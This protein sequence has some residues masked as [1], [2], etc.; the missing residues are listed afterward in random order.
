MALPKE[1]T[2]LFRSNVYPS[3][4]LSPSCLPALAILLQSY[5]EEKCRDDLQGYIW[6]R[7]AP[8]V[9]VDLTQEN[10]PRLTV[11]M[12]H[13]GSVE[14]EWLAVHL[15]LLATKETDFSGTELLKKLE[16]WSDGT[17]A[18]QHDGLIVDVSDE[19]GQFL[20][21]EGADHLPSWVQ[22]DNADGRLWLS[23]GQIHLITPDMHKGDILPRTDSV[24]AGDASAL[25]AQL[26]V[27]LVRL[28]SI[29]TAV[30]PS[31][32]NAII[33]QRMPSFPDLTWALYN[34]HS[35]LAYLPRKAAIALQL[36]PQLVANAAE[37]FEGREGPSDARRL[38]EMKVFGPQ[39]PTPIADAKKGEIDSNDTLLV[40]VRLPRRLY[41]TFLVPRY[42]PTKAFGEDWRQ[43]VSTYWEILEKS[44]RGDDTSDRVDERNHGRRRDLGCKIACG[45]ELAYGAAKER[46]KGK[47][48]DLFGNAGDAELRSSPRYEPFIASLQRIGFFGSNIKDSKEWKEKES[49]AIALWRKSQFAS[50]EDE[51]TSDHLQVLIDIDTVARAN[52]PLIPHFDPSIAA[53]ILDLQEDPDGFMYDLPGQMKAAANKDDARN[54]VE[55]D[56][57]ETEEE[58]V[59]MGQVNAFAKKLQSFVDGRGDVEGAIFEDEEE[60]DSEDD[61]EGGETKLDDSTPQERAKAMEKLIPSLSQAEWGAR[62]QN[63]PVIEDDSASVVK[64]KAATGFSR[65]MRYDGASDSEESVD[66]EILRAGDTDEDRRNRAKWLDMEKELDDDEH[67]RAQIVQEGREDE[68]QDDVDFGQ[69]ELLSFIEFTRKELGLSE[70]QYEDILTKRRARGACVPV[71]TKKACA[72]VTTDP[73]ERLMGT[74]DEELAKLKQNGGKQP[75]DIIIDDVDEDEM[76]LDALSPEDAELLEKM[77]HNGPP[78]SL[79]A[80][81]EKDNDPRSSLSSVEKEVMQSMLASYSAQ[82]GGAGPVGA[83]AGRLGIGQLP[84]N[85]DR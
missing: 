30:S 1:E 36:S 28:K 72:D 34:Q 29:D 12:R 42:L 58:K 51:H 33:A 14:D 55:A 32:T 85:G 15:L 63:A 7:E 70:E 41:A 53:R 52:A 77:L 82:M 5:I 49:E 47:Q 78:A 21:I 43:A 26:A 61:S 48:S 56:D 6:Q 62:T 31:F 68:G 39:T 37:A 27:P 11:T 3:E 80:L 13:G 57:Q 60:V 74:M 76:D 10:L 22:P 83:L 67:H 59:A 84:I 71:A 20:L 9:Q 81:L 44:T 69:D 35:T 24:D 65:K 79:R 73:F 25:S 45:L 19:D 64:T 75:D 2:P 16:G 54:G 40:K 66:G 18:T 46:V 8:R 4:R 17:I 50:E 23:N 38:R